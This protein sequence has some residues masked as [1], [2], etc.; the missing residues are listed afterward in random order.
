MAKVT[1]VVFRLLDQKAKNK[2]S[3]KELCESI[4]NT[5]MVIDTLVRMQGER[6]SSCYI[7]ICIQQSDYRYLQG[8]AQD[9]MDIKLKHHSIKGVFCVD[10]FRDA[11]QAY[12][13][14]VDDLKTDTLIHSLGDCHL[15]VM[16]VH[17]PM[18]DVVAQDVLCH[19]KESDEFI[20]RISKQPV[21]ITALFFFFFFFYFV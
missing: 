9:M 5:I 12:R 14:R 11:I 6:K 19:S 17:C 3:A 7:D 1:G 18:K 4:A 15:E 13:R 16:Q 8:T 10:D 21:A 2:E 20:F